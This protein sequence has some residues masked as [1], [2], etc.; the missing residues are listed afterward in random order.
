MN[1]NR[2]LLIAFGLSIIMML[3]FYQFYEKP[4]YEASNRPLSFRSSP[5]GAR[6]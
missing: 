5:F 2:N 3:G 6:D 1:E 4:K